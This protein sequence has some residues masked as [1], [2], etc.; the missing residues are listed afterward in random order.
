MAGKVTGL[1]PQKRSRDR[2]N[3]FLDGEYAFSIAVYTALNLKV[4]VWLSDE[5]IAR[6]QTADEG[7]RARSRALDFLSYRPRSEWEV[8]EY[9]QKREYSTAVIEA[10]VNALC[11]VKLIDDYA[12]AQYWLENRA[13]FRPKGKR[14]LSR[15]L[16]QKGV[17][18][19]QI[20]QVLETYEEEK[21]AR[22]VFEDQARRLQNQPP[23]VFRRRMLER[24]SRRGFSY[25]L[26]Q[27]LLATPDVSQS[28]Y[29][30]DEED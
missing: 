12:F 9:L 7:E 21:A 30:E 3:V 18:S 2:L 6:L 5:D 16:R 14:M 13:R 26:I 11:E 24:M 23:D 28:L 8:R 20:E 10:V 22:R 1:E 27:E 17:S 29:T 25:E 4:G 19:Q 15:E